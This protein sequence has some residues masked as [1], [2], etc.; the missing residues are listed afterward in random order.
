MNIYHLYFGLLVFRLWGHRAPCPRTAHRAEDHRRR[1]VKGLSNHT[2]LF[3]D[4]DTKLVST[5]ERRRRSRPGSPPGRPPSDDSSGSDGLP[6]GR[7][8]AADRQGDRG[9]R[10]VS[11]FGAVDR[12]YAKDHRDLRAIIGGCDRVPAGLERSWLAANELA[13]MWNSRPIR[14]PTSCPATSG[15]GGGPGSPIPG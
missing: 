13:G 15:P 12:G 11:C 6:P 5:A 2:A 7:G 9:R 14:R 4:G 1:W 3:Q 10:G 8:E